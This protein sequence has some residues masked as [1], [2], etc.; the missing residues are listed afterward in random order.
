MY[1]SEPL[2][3]TLISAMVAKC[4][5]CSKTIEP[6]EERLR[7]TGMSPSLFSSVTGAGAGEQWGGKQNDGMAGCC[8]PSG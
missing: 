7:G 8:I 3:F 1:Y 5:L 2:G 6:R 4:S